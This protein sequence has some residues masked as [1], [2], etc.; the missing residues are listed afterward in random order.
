MLMFKQEQATMSQ[1]RKVEE[2]YLLRVARIIGPHS[3]AA[4]ALREIERRRN[5]GDANVICVQH[6]NTFYVGSKKQE[7]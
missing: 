2:D 5:R 7:V 3:A 4:D 1:A 6:G